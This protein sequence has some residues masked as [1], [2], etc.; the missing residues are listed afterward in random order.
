M[1]EWLVEEGIGEDRALLIDN[2]QVLA[3]RHMIHGAP[4]VGSFYPGQLVS[5]ASGSVRGTVRTNADFDVLVDKLPRECTEGSQVLVKLT[6]API[7]ERGRLKLAQGRVAERATR[8]ETEGEGWSARPVSNFKPGLWEE[9][10]HA[11]ST[12]RIELPGGEVLCCVT[13][14]M[15]V[16]DVDGDLRPRDL[17]L[18]AI[19]AIATALRW[20]AIGG[21]VGIDFPTLEAKADRVAVDEAL[22]AAL[23]DWPHQ[24]TA[25][26]GFGFVQL[27]ARLEG[28]SLLHK[29]ASSRVGMCARF[30]LRCAERASG[31]GGALLLT[32][33]PALKARLSEGWLADL[34]RRTGREVRIETDPG[35]AL[36]APHAQIVPR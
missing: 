7:A 34:A 31:H 4:V 29:F 20:F 17:A 22:A 26:N 36:E 25:M 16:I 8:E 19:P 13:P 27:V 12:G 23:A 6:R 18:A 35:L 32:V 9:V 14:A 1:A 5:R 24:R 28:P 33:H 2:G 11:A 10:W 21:S 15:T 3:A 30:A